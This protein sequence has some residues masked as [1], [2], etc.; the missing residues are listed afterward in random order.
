M[1]HIVI[2]GGGFAGMNTAR[3]LE[4]LFRTDANIDIT[5]ISRNNYMVFTPLLPEVAG[6]GISERHAVSPLRA[7]F[8]KTHVQV[9]EV[10]KV[11]IPERTVHVTY[12]DGRTAEVHYDYLVIALGGVTNY[13]HVA[14]AATLSYDLKSL[15][16]AVR[17]RNH[18][19]AM[20]EMADT[21]TDPALRKEMLTFIAGGGG[22]AGVEGLG[23]LLDL[24]HKALRYYRTIRRDE[25]HFMLVTH[26]DRL[27]EQIDE[28]LGRYVIEALTK[29]GVDIRLKTSVTRVSEREAEISP[30]GTI[31]TRTV[32]W[33]A[34]LSIGSLVKNLDLPHA[35]NGA[36]IVDGTLQVTNHP[37]IYA[38]GDCAAVPKGE[39]FYAPT[40]QNAIREAKFAA[41]NI[42]AAMRGG[43]RKTFEYT[44]IGSLASLGH[45]Q[46]VAQVN[47]IPLRGL[48]AWFAWRTVYL[49]K[50]PEL[51][52]RI[53][54]ALDWTMDLILPTNIVQMQ[55]GP[56]DDL[57]E[58]IPT[59]TGAGD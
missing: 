17:L 27:L 23:Q 14:D 15:D 7:F 37:E 13:H 22:Y 1:A 53:R 5:I 28:R 12:A 43:P 52:R 25:L 33:A 39:R 35:K 10:N 21:T 58:S 57:S 51:S 20:L 59:V 56:N 49:A 31:S 41:E 11:Q 18:V 47:G 4:R 46:A 54:V 32:L 36:I 24:T 38:L 45:F 2:L 29:R 34:G 6:N 3:Q 26:G 8:R 48:I 19:L 44:P 9:A 42:A 40:A 55:V 50:L 30:G 16:D